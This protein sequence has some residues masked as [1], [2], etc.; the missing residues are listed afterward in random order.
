M[1]DEEN[2]ERSIRRTQSEI[3]D[4]I[5]CNPFEFFGTL[6]FDPEKIDRYD[7]K[8]VYEKTSIWLNNQ[9]RDNPQMIYLLVPERHK[10]GALH[11]HALFGAYEGNLTYSGK[12]WH[13][14]PIFN[15]PAF[16][17]GFTNFTRIEDKHKTANYCRK[18]I[19]K[20]LMTEKHKRRYWSS[21][22]LQRPLRIDNLDLSDV[23]KYPID[24]PS[25]KYYENDHVQTT[26]FP[27]IGKNTTSK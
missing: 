3:A 23:I 10:D 24:V 11:F 12:Q 1:L 8:L 19:T 17:Y 13:N 6:T 4:L 16:K 20:E 21:K 9:R 14:R 26:I 25:A 7:D 22:N 5:D 2:L 15:L 27:L 18:Y